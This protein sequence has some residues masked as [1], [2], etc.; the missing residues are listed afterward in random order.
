MP[1]ESGGGVGEREGM[2]SLLTLRW[3][4]FVRAS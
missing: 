3:D 4:L 2:F 1:L